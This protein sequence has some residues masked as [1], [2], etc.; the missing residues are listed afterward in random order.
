MVGGWKLELGAYCCSSLSL[1]LAENGPSIVAVGVRGQPLCPR[2]SRGRTR[3]GRMA[4]CL[5]QPHVPGC[6]AQCLGQTQGQI[7]VGA[8]PGLQGRE[9]SAHW[10]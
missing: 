7:R 2:Q 8:P 3:S 5:S 4:D 9:L 6:R 10:K 1:S